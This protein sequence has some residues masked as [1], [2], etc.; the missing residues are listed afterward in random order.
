MSNHSFEEIGED[1]VNL[2]EE[3]I[4]AS[5]SNAIKDGSQFI[6]DGQ[7]LVDLVRS[8]KAV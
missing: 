5:N 7:V 8:G 3:F 6:K 4:Q 2:I 1:L